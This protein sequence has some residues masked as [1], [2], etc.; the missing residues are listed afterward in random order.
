LFK[1]LLLGETNDAQKTM[2]I[3]AVLLFFNGLLKEFYVPFWVVISCHIAIAM[4][5]LAGGWKVIRTL[6]MRVT[7][8]RP[9]HGFSAEFSAAITLFL[10]SSL[11]IPVSTTH[12]ITGSIIGVGS[13]QHF[14]AVKWGVAKNIFLA[15]I[16]TIPLSA[17]FSSV[18]FYLTHF[19]A[20]YF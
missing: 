15:W 19:L 14:S 6:G 4:G 16:L 3:I 8:L 11:G 13:L 17:L 5:T 10:A 12:T 2:G 20:N 18:A 9:F 1:K 7:K